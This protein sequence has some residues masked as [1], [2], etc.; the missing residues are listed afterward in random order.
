LKSLALIV[1]LMLHAT[2]LWNHVPSST[3]STLTAATSSSGH[4]ASL[5]VGHDLSA[6]PLAFRVGNQPLHLDAA[7]AFAIDATTGTVL[8]SQDPTKHLPI[9]SVTKMITAVVIMS[10]HSPDETVTIPKLPTYDT[11]AETIGLIPGE[12]YRLGDLVEAA[13]IP[14]GNDVADALAIFD[15]GT[16]T[17]FAARMNAKMA[18]WGITDTRFSNPSGLQDSDN[19]AAAEALAKVAQLALINPFLRDTVSKSQVSFTS[20]TD[21]TFNLTTTNQLLATGKFYGIKTGYTPAAGECFVGLTRINGHEVITVVLGANDR[22]GTTQTLANWIER[23][24]EWL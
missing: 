9:A 11:A 18:E 24:W 1:T 19:Y 13:L 21:R 8:Y 5:P 14:S 7:G 4:T 16:I 23:N 10:R 20:A 22:F 17:K 12:N 3:R 2:G 6:N 15:A